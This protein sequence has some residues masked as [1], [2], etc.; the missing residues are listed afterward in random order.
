MRTNFVRSGAL[1]LALLVGCGEAAPTLDEAPPPT[2]RRLTDAQYR[3]ALEDLFGTGLFLPDQLEPD[4]RILGLNAVG[5]SVTPISSRGIERYEETSYAVAEQAVLE[6]RRGRFMPCTPTGAGDVACAREALAQLGLRVWR[7]PLSEAELDALVGLHSQAVET[8]GDFWQ[9]LVFGIAALLQDPAFLMRPELGEVG[10]DGV[11]RYTG[12]EMASRLSFLFWDAPPDAE[13]LEAARTGALDT[14]EGVE[15]QAQRLW[16][17]PRARDGVRAW[18]SDLL[19]LAELDDLH[20]DPAVF[21][22]MSDQVG[23]S[24]R[25][26]TLRGVEHLI[27]D[28]DADF[29]ELLTTRHTF[30]DRTLAAIYDVQAPAREGFG[31]VELPEEQPRVGLLGQVSFLALQAHATSSSPTLRGLFVR[32]A[33]LCQPLPDPPAGVDTSI[34]EQSAAFPTLRDRVQSH[35]T[36][37]GC[38][39]CHELTDRIGLALEPFDGLGVHRSFDGGAPIDAS[40]VLD[41]VPFDD[42]VGLAQALHDHPSLAG[43]LVKQVT[44][45]GLGRKEAESEREVMAWLTERYVSGAHRMQPLWL[46]LV[47]SPAFRQVGEVSE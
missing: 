43:C 5:A 21:Q 22:H 11:R 41:G 45:Y 46:D 37:P 33:L 7:R 34:P 17:S 3:R 38:A 28:A 9:G 1:S 2:L 8:L 6:D 25:E 15:A 12:Y 35:L 42:A 4:V 20:K 18:A 47:V 31:E 16:S 24:A 19:H 44:R 30:V 13:L 23:P 32:D 39:S 27:F 29:R 36:E 14:E 26:E 40:G 10:A